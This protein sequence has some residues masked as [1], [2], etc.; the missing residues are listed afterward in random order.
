MRLPVRSG[1]AVNGDADREASE[2]SENDIGAEMKQEKN[3]DGWGHAS[4]S[5]VAPSAAIS[6]GR[7]LSMVW[8]EDAIG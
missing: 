4:F 5:S 2:V 6:G 7:R 3:V 8:S 1:R